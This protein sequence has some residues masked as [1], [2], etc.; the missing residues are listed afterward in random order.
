[1]LLVCTL[2]GLASAFLVQETYCSNIALD[3]QGGC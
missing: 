3:E 2:A 1:M